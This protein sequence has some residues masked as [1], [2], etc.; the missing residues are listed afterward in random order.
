MRNESE[1]IWDLTENIKIKYLHLLDKFSKCH[2]GMNKSI[3]NGEIDNSSKILRIWCP[4]SNLN[5]ESPQ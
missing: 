4:I 3:V 1:D 5:S 2:R